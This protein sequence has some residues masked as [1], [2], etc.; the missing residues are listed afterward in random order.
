MSSFQCFSSNSIVATSFGIIMN[1]LFRAVCVC[2]VLALGAASLVSCIT[3]APLA[4][5]QIQDG[6]TL[7]AGKAELSGGIGFAPIIV[8]ASSE[9]AQQTTSGLTPLY[10]S[11][12]TIFAQDSVPDAVNAQRLSRGVSNAPVFAVEF[13]GGVFP[14]FDVGVHLSTAMFLWGS[15][16]GGFAKYELTDSNSKLHCALLPSYTYAWGIGMQMRTIALTVP[17]SLV[18][19]S[20]EESEFWRE[21]VLLVSPSLVH[22]AAEVPYSYTVGVT[23]SQTIQTYR[24]AYKNPAQYSSS[25]MSRLLSAIRDTTLR[26]IA[27][28]QLFVPSLGFGLQ[29]LRYDETVLTVGA[30]VAF[31]QTS[32]VGTFLFSF[33]KR[34]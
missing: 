28:P 25:Q 8:S 23:D 21:T 7:E 34:F 1:T 5:H 33:S 14:R 16:I 29:F 19:R 32:F 12:E 15:S 13:R 17:C 2:I 18:L 31:V 11:P 6:R 30:T 9:F 24:D 4:Q 3:L 10:R 27:R 26:G 20:G 22:V